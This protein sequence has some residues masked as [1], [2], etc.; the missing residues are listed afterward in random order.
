MKD[1][2]EIK[3]IKLIFNKSMS[4]WRVGAPVQ[5]VEYSLYYDYRYNRNFVNTLFLNVSN[6]T[7]KS[8]YVDLVCYD[9]ARDKIA[10]LENLPVLNVNALPEKHFGLSR[11]GC[12]GGGL[13]YFY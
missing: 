4:A 9:D 11:I 1:V 12:D 6:Q 5:I 8:I 7:I 10:T 13:P 3:D 2:S